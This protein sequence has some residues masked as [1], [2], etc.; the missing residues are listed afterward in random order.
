MQ[1]LKHQYAIGDRVQWT[2]QHIEETERKVVPLWGTVEALLTF[3]GR[4]Y[5]RVLWLGEDQAKP[6]DPRNLKL[7]A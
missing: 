4:T 2:R 3:D 7:V 5:P 6:V 1:Q